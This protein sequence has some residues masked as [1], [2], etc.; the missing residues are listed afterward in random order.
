MSFGNDNET[1]S[2][3]AFFSFRVPHAIVYCVF[4]SFAF[5]SISR[6]F[7]AFITD[8]NMENIFIIH[9]VYRRQIVLYC[10]WFAV[11]N[12]LV[13]PAVFHFV[14]F[15]VVFF[16]FQFSAFAYDSVCRQQFQSTDIRLHFLLLRILRLVWCG[17][18]A[19]SI[20]QLVK[21]K[22]EWER[23]RERWLSHKRIRNVF[24]Q[25]NSTCSGATSHTKWNSLSLYEINIQTSVNTNYH[26]MS[27]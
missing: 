18:A 8:L 11:M 7:F 6:G 12:A 25:N 9:S 24:N 17:S 13:L 27:L 4:S 22:R 1:Y 26:K 19:Q 20:L 3:V 5:A 2:F 14:W 23:K 15:L 21:K 16:L 10:Y